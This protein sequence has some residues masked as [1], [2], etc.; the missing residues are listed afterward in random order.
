MLATLQDTTAVIFAPDHRLGVGGVSISTV[1]TTSS[2]SP[3]LVF[4]VLQQPRC[5][6]NRTITRTC[7]P[8][9]TLNWLDKTLLSHI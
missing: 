5:T 8:D 3:A 4:L 6:N 7:Q 2:V 1:F 9:T